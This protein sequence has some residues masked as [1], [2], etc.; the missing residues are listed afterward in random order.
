MNPFDWFT[1]R[2][3]VERSELEKLEDVGINAVKSDET[4]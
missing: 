4:K 1:R 3:R 2:K